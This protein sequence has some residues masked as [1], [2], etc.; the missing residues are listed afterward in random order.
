MNLEDS[1]V[2]F[3]GRLN[4][5]EPLS[6]NISISLSHPFPKEDHQLDIS[7]KI[8]FPKIAIRDKLDEVPVP[9]KKE[10]V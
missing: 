4:L 5:E 7:N 2:Q 9:Q 6:S 8:N 1:N 10:Q 3:S